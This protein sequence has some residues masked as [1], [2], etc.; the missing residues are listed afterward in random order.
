MGGL[1][2]G[3]GTELGLA[4]LGG[5]AV[6][7]AAIGLAVL[8]AAVLGNELGTELGESLGG[9]VTVGDALILGAAVG[10]YVG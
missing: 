7:G 8:G 1:G 3:G 6:L 4:A 9:A 10:K 5:E 2:L